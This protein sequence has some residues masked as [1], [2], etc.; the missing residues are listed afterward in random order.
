MQHFSMFV[1][2]SV[3]F[4]KYWWKNCLIASGHQSVRFPKTLKLNLFR[5]STPFPGIPCF[6]CQYCNLLRHL[7][8]G[9][10]GSARN[11]FLISRDYKNCQ[12]FRDAYLSWNLCPKFVPTQMHKWKKFG[13]ASLLL[14]CICQCICVVNFSYF[15][16]F[17]SVGQ[18]VSW[19]FLVLQCYV[20]VWF[21]VPKMIWP[22]TQGFC[23]FLFRTKA[24]LWT[25]YF[26][27]WNA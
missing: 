15:L 23:S 11:V 18:T 17:S 21:W 27:D 8:I 26:L 25:R 9:G 14:Q 3:F 20:N 6:E 19:R 24:I 12:L 2:R 10:L 1:Q 22:R 16:S 4:S 5:C 7:L 13:T